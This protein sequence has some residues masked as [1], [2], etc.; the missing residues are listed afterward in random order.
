MLRFY[1]TK[2]DHLHFNYVHLIRF[3]TTQSGRLGETGDNYHVGNF[4]ASFQESI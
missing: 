1:G 2:L 3:F 4:L